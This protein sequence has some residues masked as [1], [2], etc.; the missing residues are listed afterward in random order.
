MADHIDTPAEQQRRSDRPR[1]GIVG[2]GRVGSALGI[3]SRQAGW[4]VVAVA[5]RDADRR[6]RFAELVPG[7]LPVGAPAELVDLVDIVLVTVPDDAIPEVAALMRL[8]PGQ[9]IVHTS[10]VLPSTVLAPALGPGAT[11]A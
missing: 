8:R 1:L 11:A 4:P 5:S 9:G 7:A 6:G 10:G 3:V 2:A